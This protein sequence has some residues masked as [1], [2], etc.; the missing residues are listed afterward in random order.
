[1]PSIMPA[2]RT[3]S[4]RFDDLVLACMERLEDRLTDR[5]AGVEFGVEEVPPSEPAPWEHRAVPL[6]RSFP[7]DRLA[8]L[9]DRIVVYRRPLLTRASS[10]DE[11]EILVR[12]VLA[13]QISH[14][15]SIP[16]EDVDPDL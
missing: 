12:T 7:G 14:L 16:L 5:L 10:E 6:G 13:E 2:W 15:L 3:R 4:D 1:M 11:L 9:N 8:G